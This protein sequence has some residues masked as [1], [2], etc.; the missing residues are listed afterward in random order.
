M[1]GEDFFKIVDQRNTGPD[2]QEID[3]NLHR[4]LKHPW[5]VECQEAYRKKFPEQPFKILCEGIYTDDDF[6]EIAHDTETPVEEIR[7]LLD[8]PTW[9]EK[10]YRLADSKGVFQP[11]VAREYQARAMRCT[12]KRKIK[13]WGR[14]LGKTQTDIIEE[15]H[16]ATTRR[17]YE[18]LV[19]CPMKSQSDKWYQEIKRAIDSDSELSKSVIRKQKAP[20]YQIVWG[21]G[22]TI[23]IFCAG[24]QSGRNADS[25]RSQSPR[26]THL[27]EMDLLEEGDHDA[28]K[29]LL[30][31][32][33]NESEFSGSSTPLGKR[34]TFWEM[35]TQDPEVMELHLPIT[36]HPD[37]G[38]EMEERCWRDARTQ[39]RY[40]HEYLAEFGDQKG[41]VF[42]NAFIDQARRHYTY[43]DLRHNPKFRYF[44]GVDWN[45]SG[46]GTCIRIIAFDPES[47]K[48]RVMGM[49]TVDESQIASCEKIRELNRK[50]HCEQIYIDA[51]FG[52]V[53][54]E[55]LKLMG[56]A[57]GADDDDQRLKDIVKIDFGGTMEFNHLTP[58]RGYARHQQREQL[59]RRTKPFLVEGAVMC[60]EQGLFEYSDA[61]SVLDDQLRAYRVKIYSAHGYAN[62][63]DS[64]AAGDHHLDATMLAL[65][66]IELRYG[67]LYQPKKRPATAT[68]MRLL[69]GFGSAQAAVSATT[70]E[71]RETEKRAAGIVSRQIE[72]KRDHVRE[73]R[74]RHLMRNGGHI[75]IPSRPVDIP[76]AAGGVPSRT[77]NLRPGNPR[78]FF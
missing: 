64:G 3:P 57:E 39:E 10:H 56:W 23:S 78:R 52:N 65:L 73:A 33:G 30:S 21:N 26:R 41:G 53:Q 61:D 20:F 13:R 31:R 28:I 62:T 5:C 48:R 77:H 15:L 27:E 34:E 29:P 42:K 51:G 69:S 76:A 59:E 50:W 74:V 38:E 6:A 63:Y 55:L 4:R 35:C 25:V 2:G 70:A 44:M 12:A 68:S 60:L 67:L 47:K 40:S 36:V 14:G 58:N 37:W 24:S 17:N 16:T 71:H 45:G 1:P 54:D 75:S 9:A 22:S 46:N 66:A 19:V 49:S 11:F 32:Y 8:R 72:S 18:T 43:A 7:E